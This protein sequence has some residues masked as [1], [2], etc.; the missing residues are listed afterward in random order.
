MER[1]KVL[2][3]N[4]SCNGLC[5]TKIENFGVTIGNNKILQNVNIHIHCGELTTIIGPNGAGKST[6]IKAILGEIKH[7]GSLKHLGEN[8]TNYKTPII[9]YVPQNLAYDVNSPISVL[10]L[11]I[12]CNTKI[13]AW[14]YSS[15]KFKK[16]VFDNLKK[17]NAE[18]LIDR[19]LGALS[20]GELQRVLLALALDPMPNIL[21]LDEPVS[22]ID[23]N[24]LVLFYNLLSEIKKKYDLAIIL[25]SHDL[26]LVSKYSDRVV[27]INGTV[28]ASGTPA[29]VFNNEE[30]QKIFGLKALKRGD[31]KHA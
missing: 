9:G 22:G 28:V 6:L 26:E 19:K 17:V 30:T 18:Y 1:K 20:G 21:I 3:I 5:C 11:F 12:A 23:Q 31:T 13:P 8:S 27:L 7:T 15:K 16:R 25:V 24:G 14:L 2:K 29:Q 4:N 10:D